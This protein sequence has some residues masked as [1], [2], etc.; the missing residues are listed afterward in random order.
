MAIPEGSKQPL[1]AEG[2]WIVT[3]LSLVLPGY[4]K[5]YSFGDDETDIGC[6]GTSA[7]IEGI[8]KNALAVKR[9]HIRKDVHKVPEV[10]TESEPDTTIFG[11][12]AGPTGAAAVLTHC[13][14]EV[15]AFDFPG[16]ARGP[17]ISEDDIRSR[18]V[19]VLKVGCA[20]T[21]IQ[22]RILGDYTGESG[23]ENVL[24]RIL[25]AVKGVI[26]SAVAKR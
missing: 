20:E 7:D 1:L 3:G 4:L 16:D 11:H 14:V 23:A 19:R 10:S 17:L 15:I 8:V 2:K 22:G 18:G 13:Q 12:S 9:G 21:P 26:G 5:G 24:K 6:G 25:I